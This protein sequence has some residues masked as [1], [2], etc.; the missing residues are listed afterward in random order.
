MNEN[1]NDNDNENEN[2]NEA[3]RRWG[4]LSIIKIIIIKLD[5]SKKKQ[6]SF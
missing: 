4:L 6:V 3:I 2:E 1:D 5:A